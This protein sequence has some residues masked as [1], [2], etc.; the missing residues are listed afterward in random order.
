MRGRAAKTVLL[1][2]CLSVLLSGCWSR[3]EL[4]E[5]AVVVALG[6]DLH[7]NG[8]AVTAQVLNPNEVRTQK[9][10][11]GATPVITYSSEGRTVPD[12]LQRML[13][14]APRML[15]LSHVRV[16]V[17]GEALARKGLSDTLDFIS[18]N[19]Q[20]R[21]DF[22]LLV[23]RGAQAADVLKIV[24]PFEHVPANSLYTSIVISHQKW[25]ATGKVTLQKFITE[26]GREGSNPVLS[27]VHV[28]GSAEKGSS[29]GNLHKIDPDAL[30]Q[31][32]GLGVFEEDRLVGWLD[33]SSSKTANYVL[34]EVHTTIGYVPCPGSGIA[35]VEIVHSDSDIDVSL[36][37]DGKPEF[38]VRLDVETNLNAAECSMDL[39]KPATIE[40]IQEKLNEKFAR[41]L[42]GNIHEVQTKYGADIFGFGEVL[43]RKYPSVWAKYRERWKDSFGGMKVSVEADVTI[44]RIGS[45][46]QPVRREMR[47]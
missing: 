42:E 41:S 17:F 19:Q 45:I 22:F 11:S 40:N 20:L 2:A 44:R 4:N 3:K 31:H 32:A 13:I 37:E 36:G 23:S 33:E 34:D 5:L 47:E 26:L 6:I 30:L 43:H 28:T 39:S 46:V 1:L 12:A 8:Y 15:Y 21:T 38:T 35:G 24:T 16:L 18:R 10:T 9:S 7:K 27:G 29:L 25:A 14:E